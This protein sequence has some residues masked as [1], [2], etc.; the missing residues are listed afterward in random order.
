[1]VDATVEL[2]DELAHAQSEL[3]GRRQECSQLS[4]EN[5]E[6]RTSL[7]GVQR[8]LRD[9]RAKES[10]SLPSAL[11]N[12]RLPTNPFATSNE[13]TKND[14]HLEVAGLRQQLQTM[15]EVYQQALTSQEN[16][17]EELAQKFRKSG[18]G[19]TSH[20]GD[21]VAYLLKIQQQQQ[22]RSGRGRLGA[23]HSDTGSHVSMPLC[24]LWH[25]T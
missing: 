3:L 10:R 9:H 12:F 16:S 8:E 25:G 17:A 2:L 22:G 1:M 20:T 7:E 23:A 21:E 18:V 15:Q 6:L 11:P 5:A 19:S 24:F 14:L 13:P 4:R